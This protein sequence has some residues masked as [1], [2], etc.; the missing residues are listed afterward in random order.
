MTIY[1]NKNFLLLWIGQ[2]VSMTGSWILYLAIL[3]LVRE[4][5]G[6]AS[7]TSIALIL[8][9]IPGVIL[10]PLAGGYV[11]RANRKWMMVGCDVISGC[12]VLSLVAVSWV[13]GG[14]TPIWYVYFVITLIAIVGTF[15]LPAIKASI[16]NIVHRD[17]L[18]RANSFF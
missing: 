10:G 14:V 7:L 2:S 12:I 3:V 9:T 17:E 16:P 13:Y 11:D 1:R 15:F 6:S 4:I 8:S 18:T 5:T